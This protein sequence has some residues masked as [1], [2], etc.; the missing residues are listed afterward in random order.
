MRWTMRRVESTAVETLPP[1]SP[2]AAVP[3]VPS[4][5]TGP[6]PPP[7]TLERRHHVPRPGDL[8]TAW[9]ILTAI[10]WL[11]IVIILAATWNA[12]RQLGL[13]TW[14]LG[15]LDHQRPVYIILLPFVAPAVD[16]HGGRQPGRATSRW[17]G[18]LG[19]IATAVVGLGDLGR[20]HGLGVVELIAAGAA[21]LL[22]I[23]SFSGMYR[24]APADAPNVTDTAGITIAGIDGG[25]VADPPSG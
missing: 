3:A 20:V 6:P 4:D 10:G 14:W 16:A 12:S 22:S 11:G 1:P 25:A 2:D 23:A 5:P 21:L 18:V 19:A 13:P 8:T 7:P 9:R 15:P 24:D 17:I